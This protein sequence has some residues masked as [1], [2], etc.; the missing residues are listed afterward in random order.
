MDNDIA[1]IT[2]ESEIPEL[3]ERLNHIL[4]KQVFGMSITELTGLLS[5]RS[6][7]CSK[8]ADGKYSLATNFSNLDGNIK[9]NPGNHSWNNGKC[10]FCGA[11]KAEYDRGDSLE[12]HAYEFIH[13][14]TPEKIFN[15][16]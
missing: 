4:N 6:L 9:F 1:T 5:R 7:Y 14:N 11:S 16:K 10:T 12:A 3:Q 2:L 13:T 15:M 8:T